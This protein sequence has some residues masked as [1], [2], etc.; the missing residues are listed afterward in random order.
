MW[1]ALPLDERAPEFLFYAGRVAERDFDLKT[2]ARLWERIGTQFSTSSWAFEGLFQ[3]GIARYRLG[4]FQ[5]A[6]STFQSALG[7]TAT[8]T[9][10]AAAYFWIGK[11]YQKWGYPEAA[12]DAWL[13]ASTSD[14]TGY[15]SERATDL[16]ENREPFDLPERTILVTDPLTEKAE[17]IT[18][19]R[20]I[21]SHPDQRRP[22]LIPHHCSL[23]HEWFT[24]GS[25]GG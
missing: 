22:E 21:F 1:T 18:W 15:Y 19:M 16:I 3:A 4:E 24:V 8:P 23:T 2:A 14:P 7:V 10:Q 20:T 9:D 12:N 5:N 13:Q 17:A 6:I 25:C 11:T